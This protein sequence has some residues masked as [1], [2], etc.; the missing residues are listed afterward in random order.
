[1][2]SE[3]LGSAGAV[4]AVPACAIRSE[5]F[6][7]A[8]SAEGGRIMGVVGRLLLLSLPVAAELGRELGRESGL[9]R[10]RS[11]AVRAMRELMLEAAKNVGKKLTCYNGTF[12][13]FTTNFRDCSFNVLKD[14]FLE[15]VDRS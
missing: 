14:T 3:L 8:V 5:I 10:L 11:T 2:T 13:C 7:L 15:N 12:I 6:E 1:M 9:P 4:K